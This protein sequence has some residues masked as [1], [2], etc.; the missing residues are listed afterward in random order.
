VTLGIAFTK[1]VTV[2]AFSD[3]HFIASSEGVGS[4]GTQLKKYI[5]FIAYVSVEIA[6]ISN[7][8]NIYITF[9]KTHALVD[10]WLHV[11]SNN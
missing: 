10:S 3:L 6:V 4:P 2:S 1:N 5:Y 7:Y 8:K 11:D 9:V